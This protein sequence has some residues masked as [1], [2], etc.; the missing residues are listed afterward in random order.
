[1][2]ARFAGRIAL[3]AAGFL[4]LCV[5]VVTAAPKDNLMQRTYQVADL[6]IPLPR[7][8]ADPLTETEKTAEE[9]QSTLEER[10]IWLIVHSV[11]SESWQ[12]NGGPG[13]IDY[14]P[15]TMTLVINQ[16]TVVQE[17]VANLLANLRR[18]QDTQVALEVRLL[19][20]SDGCLE[21]L[22]TDCGIGNDPPRCPAERTQTNPT[23]ASVQCLG[24]RS[25][26][27]LGVHF[28]DDRQVRQV[29]ELVQGDRRAN[30]LQAPKITLANGQRGTVNAVEQQ[31][32]VTGVDVHR[33]GDQTLVQP[34]VEP[35]ATGLRMTAQ[36][37]VSADCRFVKVH[38]KIDQK[39]LASPVVPLVPVVIP[40][41]GPRG[42]ATFTQFLQQPK[43]TRLSIENTV[44]VPDGG[45]VVFGGLKKVAEVRSEYGP[46]VLSKIPYLD[47]LFKNVGYARESQ[48]VLVMVTPR[49]IVSE[50]EETKCVKAVPPAEGKG[51][52]SAAEE[53]E[54]PARSWTP[55]TA[56]AKVLR[57]LLEAY[58]AACAEGRL[59]EAEKLATAALILDPTCF[60]RKR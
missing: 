12:K 58:D 9:S 56:Q 51:T 27:D 60:H 55:S 39:E 32:Y 13:S 21:R 42:E 52:A 43:F 30:I 36:P 38:L 48:V 2:P 5:P 3:V 35:E 26:S 34:R 54:R 8:A 45:T 6:V 10:L 33:T 23:G 16:T 59:G 17:Q 25:A 4:G 24:N 15:L 46:Q 29:L 31:F 28:L 14:F 19:T 20:L 44:T 41:Q 50:Q 1:M 22:G 53:E 40:C 47:R 49:I 57:E 7:A 11:S 18:Q 37:V